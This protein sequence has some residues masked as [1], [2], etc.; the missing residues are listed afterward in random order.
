MDDLRLLPK[1]PAVLENRDMAVEFTSIF[2]EALKALELQSIEGFVQE[3]QGY[4]QLSPSTMDNIDMDEM[5]RLRAEK[6]NLPAHIMR[7]EGMVQKMRAQRAKIQ[8]QQQQQQQKLQQAQI[9]QTA[10]RASLDPDQPNM[11]TQAMGM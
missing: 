10:S 5:I 3:L 4:V 9:A 11:L 1:K 6:G 8:A 2:S 7:D